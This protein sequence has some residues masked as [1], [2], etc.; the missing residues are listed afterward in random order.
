MTTWDRYKQSTTGLE[1]KSYLGD[2][3]T[4]RSY[5]DD[6]D[7]GV[8]VTKEPVCL[9]SASPVVVFE[10][11]T[12]S[13]DISASSSSTGT[14]DTFDID[15]GG[16]TSTG[17]LSSQDWSSDPL[18]GTTTYTNKGRYTITAYVTDTLGTRSKEVKIPVTV[19]DTGMDEDDGSGYNS[20]QKVYE[21]T[22]D[23]GCF[24]LTPTAAAVAS[25]T[26]LSGDDLKFRE[27]RVH[28]DTIDDPN[29]NHHLWAATASGVAYS[30][31]GAANWT[32]IDKD[33]LGDPVNTAGDGT[34][35][36]TADLDQIG[37]CFDPRNS[38]RVWVL[39]TGAT[40]AWL[41][42]TDDYGATWN[43]VQIGTGTG[44]P[45]YT[46]DADVEGWTAPKAHSGHDP[47]TGSIAW[48]S[49]DGND[50]NGCIEV[51]TAPVNGGPLH[52]GDI[53]VVFTT[54]IVGTPELSIALKSASTNVGV[55][56]LWVRAG[57]G[58]VNSDPVS[59][60]VT[61][62]WVEYTFK[63]ASPGEYSQLI[64]TCVDPTTGSPI[65]VRMDD[66]EITGSWNYTHSA[67]GLPGGILVT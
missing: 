60:A 5:C 21:G 32:V 54:S 51:T 56:P 49:G 55:Y 64:I 65:T 38:R 58:Q 35:P 46:F 15:W 47:G 12:V 61:S 22:T 50:A 7:G 34:P 6:P 20:L 13:W 31:D 66:I 1:V 10:G 18:S 59:T 42:Y 30:L 37:L 52:H 33:A 23:S 8:F 26:G 3:F 63:A 25:N 40:R 11:Q 67:G 27:M 9:F 43:N 29:G 2:V 62:S 44:T 48:I 24:V 14:I 57:G 19:M 53:G 41:Y 16:T 4:I 45:A 28:P 17:D 39:R 36:V